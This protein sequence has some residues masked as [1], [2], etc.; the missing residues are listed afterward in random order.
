M[1]SML[2]ICIV[3]TLLAM[4]RDGIEMKHLAIEETSE[5][6]IEIAL[7]ICRAQVKGTCLLG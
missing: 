1:L 6:V 7:A 2:P 4:S 5:D 3:L